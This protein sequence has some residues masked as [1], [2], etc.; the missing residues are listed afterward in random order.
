MIIGNISI[1]QYK[2]DLWLMFRNSD[3]KRQFPPNDKPF[4]ELFF[5]FFF[6]KGFGGRQGNACSGN[7]VGADRVSGNTRFDH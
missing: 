2:T 3:V 4:S 5:F 7:S 1:F 6:L